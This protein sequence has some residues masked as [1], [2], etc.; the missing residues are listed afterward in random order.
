MKFTSLYIYIYF[1]F[2]SLE[3]LSLNVLLA[4]LLYSVLYILVFLFIYMDVYIF[5]IFSF[6]L[7]QMFIILLYKVNMSVCA[8]KSI[9]E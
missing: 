7:I 5:F 6:V 9:R 2:L 3:N 4:P 8:S 1:S